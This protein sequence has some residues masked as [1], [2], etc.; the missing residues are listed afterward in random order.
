MPGRLLILSCT[1]RKVRDPR[2]LHAIDRYDGPSFRVVRRFASEC[3]D[4]LPDVHV[5][6]AKYGLI[7]SD[8]PVKWYDDRLTT[9]RRDDLRGQVTP[10]LKSLMK[11][12]RYSNVFL[13]SGADYLTLLLPGLEPFK[14]K[15]DIHVATGGLGEKLTR[16]KLWL[17]GEFSAQDITEVVSSGTFTVRGNEFRLTAAQIMRLARR[18]AENDAREAFRCHGWSVLIDGK[19]FAPKWLVAKATGLAVSSFHTDDA[20]TVLSRLGFSLS[21]AFVIERGVTT[22]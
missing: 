4:R 1:Q 12:E 18:A 10:Q 9:K 7:A 22:C 6:S 2:T 20:R 5:L 3:P 16:L 17:D 15:R 11:G 21:Q 8:T 14:A 19:R 13:F